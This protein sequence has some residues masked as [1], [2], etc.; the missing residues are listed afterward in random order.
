VG[1][2]LDRPARRR[3]PLFAAVLVTG[4]ILM[5]VCYVTAVLTGSLL[6]HLCTAVIGML[7]VVGLGLVMLRVSR[8][9]VEINH[10]TTARL[11]RLQTELDG[12]KL[13]VRS[14]SEWLAEVRFEDARRTAPLQKDLQ[15]LRRRV[16]AG[17]LG[18]I[19]SDLLSVNEEV[20]K[21]LRV[22]FESAIQL[23]R[24][25]REAISDAQASRLFTGYLKDGQYLQL[26]PLI[27]EFDLLESQSLT[28]LRH[29]FKYFRRVGYWEVAL[30]VM[31]KVH[32]KTNRDSDLRAVEKIR[33]EID[34]Y[35]HPTAVWTELPDGT[36]Y[37]STGPILH[38]VGRVLPETQ[39]GYTLRTQYTASAQKRKGLPV[40]VVAQ[41]GAGTTENA[42]VVSYSFQGVDYHILPGP[43]RNEVLIDDWL[44]HNMKRFAEL[45][46]E[47][48][49][50]IL[51]A[52]SD[53]FNELIVNAVGR[54][55][56]IPTVYESRGF[57]EESWLS[58][59][60]SANGWEEAHEML[61]A[62][63]GTPAAY[64]LRRRSEELARMLPDHVF[65]L[66]EVMRDHIISSSEGS[67]PGVLV[68]VVPNAVESS[69]FPVQSR[70]AGL[71]SEIGLPSDTITIGYISSMVE[72]E[73]VDTLI[74]AFHA[75][76]KLTSK[77]LHLLLV[78]DGDH[79]AALKDHALALGI[80]NVIFTGRVPHDEVLRY[81]SLIDVFVVPRKKTAVADLVTP[82]KPFE[83]FSTGRTVVLSDVDALKEI[84]DQSQA[85]K[86]FHAGSSDDLARVLLDLIENEEQRLELGE[87][88]QRWV[89]NHRSWS[90]NVNEYYRVYKSLG[91]AGTV[92]PV[93]E[94]ELRL[95][96]LGA[97]PGETL[98]RLIAAELPPL[99]GWF[100]I[101][102]NRQS[103]ESILETGWKFASFAP[104]KVQSLEDW[105]TYGR[106]HRSWGFHLHA[107]EFMD[108][109]LREYDE[110]SD[111]K[112]LTAAVRIA[113]SWLNHHRETN[114][115]DSMAW[116]DMSQALRMPRLIALA[117]R[118]A[119]LPHLR[120]ES[121]V[122]AAGIATHFTELRKE[123]SYNPN[124]NH[125]FYTAASQAHGAKY[126]W[127]IPGA[128]EAEEIGQERLAE[129]AD[130]QF[131]IDGVHLEHSPDYHRMLLS[132][133]EQALNDGLLRSHD[134]QARVRR[135]ANVLGWMIQPDGTLV[136]FGDSPETSVL[137]EDSDSIDPATAYL[138]SGGRK[139]TRPIG[140]LA[141]F[142]EGG[143]AFVRSPQ[144]SD[145]HRLEDGSYLAFSAAFH[146]RAHKHADDLNVVWFDHGHQILTD[147]GRFGYGE[148]LPADSP[149]RREGFY[150][151][152]AERRYVE[153]TMAHNTL[154][155]D[156]ANQDRRTREPYGGAIGRCTHEDG[157][158]DLSGRVQHQDYIHRR[159]LV[160]KP[161]SELL[162][163]D[164]IFS[165]A[166]EERE[167]ILWF[168]V[169]GEFELLSAGDSV[170]FEVADEAGPVN[171]TIEGPGRLL[172]PVRGQ[173]EPLR[174]WR[175]RKDRELEPVWSLGFVIPIETRASV[176][177]VLRLN[178]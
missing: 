3:V 153:G 160:F 140:E 134:I 98:E 66:A 72:Y 21:T 9:A 104:V 47:L 75:V 70:D 139:G 168:N 166:A 121:I 1:T 42:E 76:T 68:S 56:G 100:S 30:L 167:A 20:E 5:L 177:T 46:L 59:T 45:V 125:G 60:I 19:E 69:K 91:F 77:R 43:L 65:T 64:H 128:I 99:S 147:A 18:R 102:E 106:E 117:L 127:M 149:L 63:Y 8:R 80:D 89:R 122:L 39:T 48:R 90:S 88:A 142:H 155:M 12:L 67:I 116:Y 120:E 23:G 115:E 141:V 22:A 92:R 94:A 143:Y 73:G 119:R 32:E 11:S 131:A 55:Y 74:D 33:S 51:H 10:R 27:E 52:Q 101:Q 17:F 6:L 7:G 16:P 111:Q 152:A 151:A 34:L 161:G 108:P 93:V 158:F 144:P 170:E 113:T 86:T 35:S 57:W 130:S 2:R 165:Q 137:D 148:L 44:R 157:T 87:Q 50:S 54:K 95:Q 154:M 172:D 178:R 171:L 53:F 103:A 38:F 96:D 107:W 114:D 118:A 136:Q 159:R 105:S 132:S 28:T 29:L 4:A 97:N 145:Q 84:A 24:K 82:L 174:G 31:T 129:M 133:F 173:T 85:A 169:S 164:S 62:M 14:V 61:F 150:Y 83:A 163:K 41:S 58:R 49:P 81:Y 138:Q 162:I 135:A 156:G 79:L 36:A 40:A 71:A 109:L 78:G 37:D 110:T 15:I 13:D 175:S 123:R 26:R 146:S 25:P 112:W 126:A 124:N 176:D